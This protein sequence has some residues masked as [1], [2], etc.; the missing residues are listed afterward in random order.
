[1]ETH[2]Y[3][4]QQQIVASQKYPFTMGQIRHLLL[5]RHQNNLQPAVRKIGKRIVI[6]M[7]TFNQWIENQPV[8]KGSL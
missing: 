8:K 6:H 7:D 2:T 1:M 5:H 3:W 4:T